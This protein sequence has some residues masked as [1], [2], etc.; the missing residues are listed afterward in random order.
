MQLLAYTILAGTIALGYGFGNIWIGEETD[1]ISESLLD[2][3]QQWRLYAIGLMALIGYFWI[4]STRAKLVQEPSRKS[5]CKAF[6]AARNADWR[7]VFAFVV[8]ALVFALVIGA[9]AMLR[10]RLSGA[11]ALSLVLGFVVAQLII[12]AMAWWRACRLRVLIGR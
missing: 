5:V 4:E 3:H 2:Q 10:I 1:Y 6:W 12:A 11:G 7:K 8:V 9:L